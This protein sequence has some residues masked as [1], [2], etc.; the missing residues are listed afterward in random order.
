VL[1]LGAVDPDGRGA[2]DV[3]GVSGRHAHGGAGGGGLEA[4]VEARGVAVHRDGLARVVE[5][6][7]RRRV[8]AGHELELDAVA[9]GRLEAL[10]GVLQRA[11]DADGDYPV[12]LGCP[13]LLALLLASALLV[14]HVPEARLARAAR[15]SVENC[16][17][18]VNM[19]R[20]K[21]EERVSSKE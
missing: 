20:R 3:D 12:L 19:F 2:G 11:V 7:L 17:L 4:R 21:D 1:A 6:R 16:I 18:N 13:T 8:V 10:G 5:G 15:T 14:S 9:D